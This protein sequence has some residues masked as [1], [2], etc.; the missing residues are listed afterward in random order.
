MKSLL[1]AI[2]FLSI[3]PIKVKGDVTTGD[4]LSSVVFFPVVGLMQGAVLLVAG[5]GMMYIFPPQVTAALLLLLLVLSYGGLHMDGLADT[6]DALACK[7]ELQRRLVVMRDGAIGPVGTAAIIF[8]LLIKYSALVSI[9]EDQMRTG[10]G[11]IVLALLF[12]PALSKWV[13]L[14]GMR[15][16]VPARKDGLG[17]M[18]ISRATVSAPIAGGLLLMLLMTG[19]VMFAGWSCLPVWHIFSPAVFG[20]ILIYAFLHNRVMLSVFGGQTGDTLGASGEIV[21]VIYLLMVVAWSRNFI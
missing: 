9:V 7:G 3:I 5:V 14:A 11:P 2:Q 15:I 21:E 6:A 10:M 19:A 1:L 18:F 4:M 12:M 17:V 13:M 8:T 16:S 20:V